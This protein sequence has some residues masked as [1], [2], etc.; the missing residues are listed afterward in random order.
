[1]KKIICFVVMVMVVGTVLAKQITFS[2]PDAKMPALRDAMEKECPIPMVCDEEGE[3][4]TPAWTKAKNVRKCIR[5]YI[6]KAEARKRQRDKMDK[7]VYS[8]D[9]TLVVDE[10]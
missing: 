8:E 6:I 4:C 9:E 2:F 7:A 10:E 1:M 3:N 5:K